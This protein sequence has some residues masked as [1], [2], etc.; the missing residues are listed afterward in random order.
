MEEGKFPPVKLDE[1]NASVQQAI[2]AAEAIAPLF[3]G[4]TY[5]L[6]PGARDYYTSLM[7]KTLNAQIDPAIL[8]G[9]TAEQDR[10][11]QKTLAEAHKKA[12]EHQ[13]AVINSFAQMTKHIE[14]ITTVID[15]AMKVQGP[16]SREEYE[17]VVSYYHGVQAQ[18]EKIAK[19]QE[20]E[21]KLAD[22]LRF[23]KKYR[24]VRRGL[25]RF[26][27]VIENMRNDSLLKDALIAQRDETIAA[28]KR[29]EK[30]ALYA[31]VEGLRAEKAE[32][33]ILKE[34][35]PQRLVDEKAHQQEIERWKGTAARAFGRTGALLGGGLLAGGAATALWIGG[36]KASEEIAFMTT[37]FGSIM[38]GGFSGYVMGT[39][40]S[41][42][43]GIMMGIMGG[44]LT[45]MM[46]MLGFMYADMRNESERRETEQRQT[47]QTLMKPEPMGGVSFSLAP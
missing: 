29:T 12:I 37:I 8:Q 20:T 45:S 42:G 25:G 15:R 46:T 35:L 27:R 14:D 39:Q 28:M 41:V 43:G 32:Y 1:I 6:A 10:L 36:M 16:V 11:V 47:L 38:I 26:G 5:N 3:D 19:L 33:D 34:R 2:R 17:Q 24:A 30:G 21:E 9:D 4:A 7:N 44:L 13:G 40:R 22:A 18:A 31:E 23:E